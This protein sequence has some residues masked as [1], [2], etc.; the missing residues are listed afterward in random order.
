[1]RTIDE[2]EE[3]ILKE[4]V[5]KEI[6]TQEKIDEIKSL[7]SK[8]LLE[9][10]VSIAGTVYSFDDND[11]KILISDSIS[12]EEKGSIDLPKPENFSFL[13]KEDWD[14]RGEITLFNPE[15]NQKT[16][17]II[18]DPGDQLGIVITNKFD[19]IS[20]PNIDFQEELGLTHKLI[21]N[22]IPK[23]K[24]S[25]LPVDIFLS[26]SKEL[27]CISDRAAGIIYLVD[28][29][30]NSILGKV[31]VRPPGSLKSLNISIL[32]KSKKIYITDNTTAALSI[33]DMNNLE[34]ERKSLGM[35]ILGNI[36]ISFDEK[37]LFLLITKP[38]KIIKVL[39]PKDFS[40]IKDIQLKGELFSTSSDDP[41]DLINISPD[42]TNVLIMTFLDEPNP[43]TPVISVINVEKSKTIQRFAIK[44]GI[45]PASFAFS[46]VNPIYEANKSI[47]D[48]MIEMGLVTDP[49]IRNIR[50]ELKNR[51]LLELERKNQQIIGETLDIEAKQIE[52]LEREEKE[53]GEE[54]EEAREFK[55]RKVERADISP[56]ADELILK[57]CVDSF[58]Q[59]TEIELEGNDFAME[60]LK[61]AVTKARNELE[62]YDGAII[63]LKDLAEGNDFKIVIMREAV[64]EW[65]RQ[66][67]RDQLIFDGLRTIPQNCPNCGRL[68][69]GSYICR[70]CGYELE[71]P[72][73][74]ILSS[75]IA[76]R[77]L[78]PL[79]NLQ[80]GNFLIIDRVGKRILEVD[81]AYN[82]RWELSKDTIY[83]DVD[84]QLEFPRDAVRLKNR[85]TLITDKGSSRVLEITPKGRIFWEFDQYKSPRHKLSEP[86]RAVPQENRNILIV[87]KGNHRIL[88]I[89]KDDDCRIEF[90][91]G[92]MGVAGIEDGLLSS[93]SDIQRL[94]NGNFI[95]ADTENHRVI[96]LEG[97][98]IVWQYG[99]PENQ[100]GAYGMEEG[101]LS[102][103]MSVERLDTGNTLIVDAGNNRVIEVNEKKEIV[104]S[105]YTN[106]GP[107][108]FR[109]DA[110]FRVFRLKNYNILI[111]GETMVIEVEQVSNK[112]IWACP[113]AEITSKALFTITDQKI[114]KANIKHGTVNPYLKMKEKEKEEEQARQAAIA[115]KVKEMLE[116]K[117]K[118]PDTSGLKAHVAVSKGA[119][120]LALEMVFAERNRNRVLKT[121]RK[122]NIP[123]KYGDSENQ[124]LLRPN[125]AELL[126]NKNVLI[127][128]TDL[129]RVIEVNIETNEIVWQYGTDGIPG[130]G[131]NQ[132]NKPRSAIRL[133]NG[134]TLI[135]D[136]GNTRVIEVNPNHEIVWEF[137]GVSNLGGPFYAIRLRK[138]T[139]ITDWT[140]HVVIE[141]DNQSKNI[142]WQYGTSKK[143]GNT[144]G[145]LSYPEYATK[146]INGNTLIADT[147]NNRILEV[148]KEG[149]IV[150]QFSE[151]LNAP[152]FVKRMKNDQTLILHAANRQ[153]LEVDK[154]GKLIWKYIL[155]FDKEK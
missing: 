111:I 64:L 18:W 79:A 25:S 36:E 20:T 113:I 56:V 26:N 1:M 83:S 5:E 107:E 103:P 101:Y 106:E 34:I 95:I 143:S 62:W 17:D 126:L 135:T 35:G 55:P 151:K 16:G 75:E 49:Q 37:Q 114:K 117:R 145:F 3:Q 8:S 2:K 74:A 45:K 130:D 29:N 14:K 22:A 112:I 60:R 142:I 96:E 70:A 21:F 141:I 138:T 12:K 134:N 82:L 115:E 78:D 102:F 67:E 15:N 123:W 6:V 89:D 39:N 28:I 33:V 85:N 52:E 90:E 97:K 155:P 61:N 147:R 122:G 153:M 71:R 23:S 31:S 132:L 63:K 11:Y 105:Y 10:K 146:L 77:T 154:E 124:K 144:P 66:H 94:A 84:Y 120:L 76:L 19:Y 69:L 149:Q 73:D 116:K 50:L 86:V 41:C 136:Q 43:H 38:N 7:K 53:E 91:Y 152:T 104:W 129:H 30:K 4:L 81:M 58:Y 110:P 68:L 44:D 65:I 72:E 108:K 99:N 128:D 121:D 40:L 109:V 13:N 59:Q 80:H 125:F 148:N 47:I 133:Q 51:E 118:L 100:P 92:Q 27:M 87:D 137:G 54:G 150:W 24:I 88:E 9:A 46:K 131:P 42:G 127:S 48:M 140:N 98:R 57:V 119:K 93:P 32:E 139:L